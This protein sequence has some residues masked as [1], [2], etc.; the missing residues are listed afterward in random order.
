MVRTRRDLRW[1]AALLAGLAGAVNL[2]RAGEPVG[3]GPVVVTTL[4][5]PA[6]ETAPFAPLLPLPE[7]PACNLEDCN[8][9][10][11]LG[12]PLL[13]PPCFPPG[14]F[15]AAEVSIVQPSLHGHLAG[16][17]PLVFG[18][19]HQPI[20]LPFGDLS[21]TGSPRVELGYRFPQGF[22]ELL[23]SYRFLYSDGCN[24]PVNVGLVEDACLY[25]KV[26][27]NVLDL[28]YAS[29][30]WSLGPC[31]DMKWQVGVR[32]ADLCIQ[33]AATNPV[34]Q[35]W[36]DS[37][38]IGAGPHLALGLTRWLPWCRLGLFTRL[39]GSAVFGRVSQNFEEVIQFFGLPLLDGSSS[40]NQSQAVPTLRV[41]SGV[42]WLAPWC[43]DRL[44]FAGGY[45]FEEWWFVGRAQHS[46]ADL[47]M[48]GLFLRCEWNF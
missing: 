6:E 3:G 27:L 15:T 14:W 13:D 38:F 46:R 17:I 34:I 42:R 32:L 10:I 26:N 41:Q 35:Q 5:H 4:P 40:Q 18:L 47:M 31:W 8:G 12:D 28:D 45:E 48:Q 16:T 21:W 37:R 11:L 20:L 2:G 39:E 24:G 43:G 23:L 36:A 1:W 9:P 30:E 19:I 25:S 22:G 44:H 33:T 29:H 7:P